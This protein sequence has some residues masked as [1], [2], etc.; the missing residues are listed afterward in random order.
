MK[1]SSSPSPSSPSRFCCRGCLA[2][3]QSTSREYDAAGNVIKE[4][5]TSKSIVKTVAEST[6]DKLVYL[7]GQS[8]LAGIRAIPRGGTAENPMGTLEILAGRSDK[9]MLTMPLEK[10]SDVAAATNGI[11]VITTA[12]CAGDITLS[13]TG[14]SGRYSRRIGCCGESSLVFTVP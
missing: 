13:A 9:T 5:V 12:V 8:W 14:V 4:T 1:K 11:E 2:P 6:K 10:T 3:T 7:N